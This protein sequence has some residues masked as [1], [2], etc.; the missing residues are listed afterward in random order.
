M[1]KRT[2][3]ALLLPALCLATPALAQPSW[4]GGY[5]SGWGGARWARASAPADDRE[6]KVDA[7]RFVADG[8]APALGKG[9]IAV[10]TLAGSPV[11]GR[12]QATY[13]AAI[14]DQLAKG[15]Y[16][17]ATPD[18]T[19][20]QIVEITITHDQLVPAEEKRNPLS[21]SAT[22][23][24]SNRGSMMGLSLSYDATKPRGAL[25]STGL[26]I[27]IRD[28]LSGQ[29]LYE[30]RARIAT[31]TGDSRW[32]DTAIATRLAAALFERF[33]SSTLAR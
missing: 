30:A 11:E 2:L 33:P 20:G 25:V 29:A 17:T 24:V 22:M 12:E 4:G 9:A 27:R 1:T 3:P 13:E 5:G 8:A 14:I 26:E 21:G 18:Q 19:G 10:K 6:G 32:N 16:D 15:G 31:R 28:R 23:G 7:E